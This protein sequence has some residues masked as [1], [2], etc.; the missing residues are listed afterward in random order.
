MQEMS[1]EVYELVLNCMSHLRIGAWICNPAT[2]PSCTTSAFSIH[3]TSANDS[4]QIEWLPRQEKDDECEH[5]V[6]RRTRCHWS[7]RLAGEVTIMRSSD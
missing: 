7:S 3:D 1:I 6:R 2:P 5:L 4:K